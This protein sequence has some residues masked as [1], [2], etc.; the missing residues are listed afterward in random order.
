MIMYNS[1]SSRVADHLFN[2]NFHRDPQ[3]Q[4]LFFFLGF[5]IDSLLTYIAIISLIN[6]MEAMKLK[7]DSLFAIVEELL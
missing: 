2:I 6:M 5:F 7:V 3:I 4:V 1:V